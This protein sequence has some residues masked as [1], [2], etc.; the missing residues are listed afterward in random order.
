MSRKVLI[1]DDS[2][3]DRSKLERI[4][5]DAGHVT[6]LAGSGAQAIERVSREQVLEQLKG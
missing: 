4:V 1:V 6:L 2:Q 5:A 3:V